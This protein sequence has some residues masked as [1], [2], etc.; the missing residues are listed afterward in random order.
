MSYLL[1]GNMLITCQSPWL[2]HVE[3]TGRRG[4]QTRWDPIVAQVYMTAAATH[5][6]G[7]LFVYDFHLLTVRTRIN[8]VRPMEPD[9]VDLPG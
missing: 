2:K 4:D 6:M 1:N 9:S 7:L 8:A 3:G 5:S